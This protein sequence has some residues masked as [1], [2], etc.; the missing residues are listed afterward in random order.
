MEVSLSA[1]AVMDKED[2]LITFEDHIRQ[3]EVEDEEGRMKEKDREKREQRTNRDAFLVRRGRAG[4]GR[5]GEGEGGP[6]G[7]TGV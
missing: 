2:M 3:L 5:G 4:R 6:R 1:C 7:G